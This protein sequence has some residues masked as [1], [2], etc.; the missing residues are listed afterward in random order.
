MEQ[1][2][3][4][5]GEAAGGRKPPIVGQETGRTQRSSDRRGEGGIFGEYEG[6]ERRSGAERRSKRLPS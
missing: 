4:S 5:G 2:D 3:T 6:P 1:M